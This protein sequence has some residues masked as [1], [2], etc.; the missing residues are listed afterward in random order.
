MENIHFFFF[1]GGAA[2]IH[3]EKS[4]FMFSRFASEMTTL[5]PKIKDLNVIGAD[6]EMPIYQ[7]FSS[8]ITDLK[9]ALM[10]VSFGEA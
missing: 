2:V 4:A 6:Q 10:G 5:Q 8:Q 9:T 3:F 7:G 1:G